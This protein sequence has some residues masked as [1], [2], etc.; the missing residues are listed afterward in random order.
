M[1]VKIHGKEYRTVAERVNLFHEENKDVVKSIKTKILLNNDKF[2]AMRT[3]IKIG[4]CVYHGHAQ[5]V[6]GSSHINETSALENCETSA[7][8][9]ALAS[10]GFGGTEFASADEVANAIS[11]QNAKASTA[12]SSSNNGQVQK[13]NGQVQSDEPYVHTDDARDSAIT[14]GKHKGELWRDLPKDYVTWLANNSDNVKW[15]TMAVAEITARASENM[16]AKK[17]ADKHEEKE[18]QRE[19]QLSSEPSLELGVDDDLPF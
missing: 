8:G 16:D 1:S 7:I 11:Q 19:M 2:V 5:E 10:A 18:I 9:R 12:S 15:Q 3:T 6:Y 4:D 13:S 17:K 14:F